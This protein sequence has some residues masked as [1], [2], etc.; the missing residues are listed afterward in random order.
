MKGGIIREA[1]IN[2]GLSVAEAAALVGITK[3]RLNR[4]ELGEAEIG[5]ADFKATIDKLLNADAKTPSK[6]LMASNFGRTSTKDYEAELVKLEASGADR[7]QVNKLKRRISYSKW[8]EKHT[9]G[10]TT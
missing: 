7:Q 3:S 6:K 8:Y 1:R 5:P 9:T 2:K 4:I 10:A